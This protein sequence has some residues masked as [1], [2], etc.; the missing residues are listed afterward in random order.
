MSTRIE[1]T[2]LAHGGDGIGRVDGK[3]V[4]VEGAIPGDVVLVEIHSE[5]PRFARGRVTEVV[6]ASPHRVEAPCPVFG[7]CGGCGLQHAEYQAQLTWKTEV[8]RSQ[9]AHLGRLDPEVRPTSAVG[10]PYRYRNR[11]DLRSAGGRW[12]MYEGAS[13]R[14]IPIERCLLAVEPLQRLMDVTPPT[15]KATLRVGV[16]TGE[17]AVITPGSSVAPIHEQVAGHRFRITG[18]A[19]FQVNTAGAGKLVELVGEAVAGAG[20]RMLD[21]YCGGGLFSA[22]VGSGFDSV[23]GIESD[24]RALADFSVNVPDGRILAGEVAVNLGRAGRF[25]VAVVDPPR[26]GMGVEVVKSLVAA[27]PTL[28][29]AVSCDPATFAR[30]ARLLT[31]AGYRLEW[32]QPVD[33]FPQTPHVET[34]AR[35]CR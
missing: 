9:L 21:A 25:E 26:E 29:V 2:T 34:V 31:D 35:F 13:H 33:M 23:I 6:V 4:L 12:A 18:R 24:R 27:S 30:D 3:T 15:G 8:V 10:D 5:K 28:I 22:T 19:F 20:G 7:R 17:T 11:I 32:V 14:P 16:A 1:I